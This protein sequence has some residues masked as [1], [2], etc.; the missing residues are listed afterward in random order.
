MKPLVQER[1]PAGVL[2][3]SHAVPPG[4]R[5]HPASGLEGDFPAFLFLL[6][7]RGELPGAEHRLLPAV[8]NRDPR[9]LAHLQRNL[10]I[11]VRAAGKMLHP[12]PDH[13]FHR[14]TQLDREQRPAQRVAPMADG[15]GGCMDQQRAF[16]LPDVMN[17]HRVMDYNS[18]LHQ[19]FAIAEFH[20]EGR[21]QNGLSLNLKVKLQFS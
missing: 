14:R 19:P 3:V 20:V 16:H 6:H 7:V 5:Q 10:R 21:H 11:P 4:F 17:L 1:T 8:V 13:I 18:R 15:A 2:D 9:R 12:D